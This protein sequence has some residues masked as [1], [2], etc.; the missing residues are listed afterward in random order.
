[1]LDFDTLVQEGR[2]HASVYSDPAIFE[3]EMK[4]VFE[5]S[6]VYIGHE[7]EVAHAGDYKR[8][9]MGRQPVILTRDKGDNLHVLLNRCRH[10]G[11]QVCQDE[12]GNS[13]FFRCAYHGWT[14]ENNGDLTGVTFSDAYDETFE[15]EKMGLL[16]VPRVAS[17][18]GFVFAS[19]EVNVSE[20]SDYLAGAAEFINEFSDLSLGG[21]FDFF[22]GTQKTGY[23]GNWK[24]SM[25]N[26]MD[27][28]HPDFVHRSVI[29]KSTR[30]NDSRA[31]TRDL[32]NG[33]G[34]IDSRA[35][36]PPALDGS[37]DGGGY[38]MTVFPNLVVLK[39][40]VRIIRPV[41]VNRTE[42][43]TR[44]VHLRGL[45]DDISKTRLRNHQIGFGPAGSISPDDYE[46]F[47][48]NREGFEAH[49]VDWVT[50]MRGLHSEKIEGNQRIGG[51]RDETPQRGFWRQW[52]KLTSGTD[53]E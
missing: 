34:V 36:G 37:D 19:L 30:V 47:R 28:Y 9:T 6:W 13:S 50:L 20:L 11:T 32:G 21:E 27:G 46:M 29:P 45:E 25:E 22:E 52:K 43:Y 4:T 10:R 18:R 35:F 48:R 41:S 24:F 26:G 49:S 51:L 15:K 40:Q 8:A 23:D 3:H 39:S 1:M 5:R 53:K 2:V 31:L 12:F 14:Y 17:Y 42:V 33:H 38:Y 7:A 44:V 16:R